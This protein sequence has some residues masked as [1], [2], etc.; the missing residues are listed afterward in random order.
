MLIFQ[1]DQGKADHNSLLSQRKSQILPTWIDMM[2]LH[3]KLYRYTV[4]HVQEREVTI[5]FQQNHADWS[6]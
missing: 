1:Q 4:L 3:M 2:L 6:Y 5:S